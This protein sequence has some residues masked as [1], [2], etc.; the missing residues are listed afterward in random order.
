[1]ADDLELFFVQISVNEA[2]LRRI[3]DGDHPE[4]T[5]LIAM[6]NHT[7]P[8][9]ERAGKNFSQISGPKFH[10]ASHDGDTRRT[11]DD[12]QVMTC[13]P[14]KVSLARNASDQFFQPPLDQATSLLALLSN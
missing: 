13:I 4:F 9:P 2:T 6:Q 12:P 7:Q 10:V 8:A 3:I 1:M 14:G 11:T 5:L